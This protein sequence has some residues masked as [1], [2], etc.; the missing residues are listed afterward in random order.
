MVSI[1]INFNPRNSRRKIRGYRQRASN[2]RPVLADIGRYLTT[3][4]KR[5]HIREQDYRRKKLA[6][7]Q[8][9][10][11]ERRKTLIKT[12]K[13]R[14]SWKFTA[15][16]QDLLVEPRGVS[17]YDYLHRGGASGPPREMIGFAP[18]HRREIIRRVLEYIRG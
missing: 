14:R 1:N 3:D 6:P 11:R 10:R 4:V 18:R 8:A 2:L 9:A 12:G 5:R 16:K 15:R 7:S 17:Y 13:L